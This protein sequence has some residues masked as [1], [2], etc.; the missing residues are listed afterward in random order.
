[1]R[2]KRMYLYE[3]YSQVHKPIL[4]I[5]VAY[6]E[7]NIAITQA[8]RLREINVVQLRSLVSRKSGHP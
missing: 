1:M 7:Y 6:C 3:V 5:F 8:M 2:G 4:H